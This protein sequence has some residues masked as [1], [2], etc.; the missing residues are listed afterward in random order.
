MVQQSGIHELLGFTN[1]RHYCEE[2]LGLPART[3]EQRAAL[4]KR[5]S[6]SPAL[7]EA[8]RQKVSFEKLRLLAR[9]PEKE[10][11][12]WTPRAH[13]LTC[14]AL[15]RKLDAKRERQIPGKA[16]SRAHPSRSRTISPFTPGGW[17]AFKATVDTEAA[18]LSRLVR[19]VIAVSSSQFS[20]GRVEHEAFACFPTEGSTTIPVGPSAAIASLGT[21]RGA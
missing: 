1:F 17:F 2:R 7:R 3:V 5:L 20:T 19:L 14:I 18:T 6:A 16:V 13:A 15:E 8:R 21:S 10:I 12:A 4:E 9:L 11:G